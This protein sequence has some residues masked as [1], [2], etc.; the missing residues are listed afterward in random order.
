[1]QL[2]R[3]NLTLWTA[4]MHV[5]PCRRSAASKRR[6]Y[7]L[8]SLISRPTRQGCCPHCCMCRQPF[9]NSR[10][11]LPW[12]FA[13]QRGGA[14]GRR[15]GRDEGPGVSCTRTRRALGSSLKHQLRL[16][17]QRLPRSSST[18]AACTREAHQELPYVCCA[19]SLFLL[20]VHDVALCPCHVC[21]QLGIGAGLLSVPEYVLHSCK[22][23]L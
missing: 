20:P 5:G 19:R 8:S 9:I 21:K 2:L 22:C 17:L 12:L 7:R 16:T 18:C 4:D 15:R 10:A 1:M 6:S 14:R 3:D 23:K 13:G 11:P